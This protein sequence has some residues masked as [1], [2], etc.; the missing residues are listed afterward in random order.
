MSPY[1]SS[2]RCFHTREI[3]DSQLG[4]DTS[5]SIAA[6]DAFHSSSFSSLDSSSFGTAHPGRLDNGGWSSC[7]RHSAAVITIKLSFKAGRTTGKEDTTACVQRTVGEP[8]LALRRHTA[9]ELINDLGSVL[10]NVATK[11]PGQ[12]WV[13]AEQHTE[14]VGGVFLIYAKPPPGIFA[15]KH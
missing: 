15:C 7:T 14:C 13:D 2:V 11:A 3:L 9:E 1:D 8:W 5:I 4:R 6:I 10:Y 12:C